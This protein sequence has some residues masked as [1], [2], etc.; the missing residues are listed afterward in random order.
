MVLKRRR[1][2]ERTTL[3]A[4]S[5]ALVL[6]AAS[7]QKIRWR[8]TKTRNNERKTTCVSHPG[9]SLLC[10]LRKLCGYLRVPCIGK[11]M[12]FDKR[13]DP[14]ICNLAFIHSAQFNLAKV[15]QEHCDGLGIEA[16]AEYCSCMPFENNSPIKI[17]LAHLQRGRKGVSALVAENTIKR[18]G[19][20]RYIHYPY[21]EN[22]L[23]V[24]RPSFISET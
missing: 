18:M 23:A 1:I 9:F 17:I 7:K 19:K 22:T 3:S 6:F 14:K 2:F 12:Q 20:M 21:P 16:Y 4:V 15:G 24:S 5:A 13:A 11:N 8:L 10:L